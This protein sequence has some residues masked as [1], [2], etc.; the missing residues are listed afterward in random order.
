[1][2]KSL[3]RKYAK[4]IVVVGANVQKGQSVK[5]EADVC[6]EAFAA[7]V[8]D[9][10]YKAGAKKVE[11]KWNSDAMTKLHYRHQSLKTLS[12][13][14][15]W[16]E[17]KLQTEVDECVCRILILSEDPD[18]LKGVNIEKMQKANQAVR[19]ITKK[20]RDQLEGKQQWTIAA[21]PSVPWAKKVFPELRAS[22]AVEK[23]WEAI[24]ATVYVSEDTDP[25]EEWNRHNE[26]F[27]EKCKLLNSYN[28]ARMEYK[29]SNGTDF[30]VGLI[31]GAQWMGGGEMSLHGIY[32]NPNMPTEEIFTSPMKGDAEGTVVSTKPLA[33]QGQVIDNFSIT[34][35]GGKA[36]SWKAE[37]GEELLGKM[38]TLDE[39]AAMLGELALVPVSSP[40]S[41]SNILYFNTL[42][43]ENASCHLAIGF[44]FPNVIEGYENKTLDEI[45]AL[46]VNDSITHTDFMIG[47]DDMSI[48]GYTQDGKCVEIFRNGNWAI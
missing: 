12:T 32:F 27:L 25:V 48:K 37:Q 35:K 29:S 36:V 5:V 31:P 9:E 42:F 16:Q 33:Y 22:A 7:M 26:S 28:F 11:I 41:E 46:G 3:L 34:F 20:Y 19:K 24:L 10:A 13:V 2:K 15:A 38:L 17:A 45:H 47:S 8:V 40:I 43:D 30:T 14:P 23:L 18:G 44:G 4:A 21:A 1:M 39:G 6:N